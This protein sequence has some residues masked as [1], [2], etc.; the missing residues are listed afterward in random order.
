MKLE[1]NEFYKTFMNDDFA[2]FRTLLRKSESYKDLPKLFEPPLEN[3]FSVFEII[4]GSHEDRSAKFICL[5]WDELNLWKD[6]GFLKIKNQHNDKL[7]I[8]CVIEKKANFRNFL[9]FLVFDWHNPNQHMHKQDKKYFLELKNEQLLTTKC[10]SIFEFLYE[11]IDIKKKYQ[12]VCLRIIYEY[13]DEME[14]RIC[15]SKI[16]DPE[17]QQS[18]GE[19]LVSIKKLFAIKDDRT[20]NFILQIC[21]TY[22]KILKIDVKKLRSEIERSANAETGAFFSLAFELIDRNHSRFE[23]GFLKWSEIMQKSC[24]NFY[25]TL[26]KYHARMLLKIADTQNMTQ[27]K[28]FIFHQCSYLEVNSSPLTIFEET[29]KFNDKNIFPLSQKEKKVVVSIL[30]VFKYYAELQSY[31]YLKTMKIV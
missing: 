26:I 23:Q 7:L 10:K 20:R 5:I 16:D 6:E 3:K 19:E 4:L 15:C 22:Y 2:K 30:L 18:A 9:S 13:L 24:G 17:K 25:K 11:I 12:R 31:I 14:Q 1:K 8:E 28:A 29:Y 27:V 21:V